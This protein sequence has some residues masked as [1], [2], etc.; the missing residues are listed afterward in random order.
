MQGKPNPQEVSDSS[1]MNRQEGSMLLTL[2]L[3]IIA[4]SILPAFDWN[5]SPPTF[6]PMPMFLGMILAIIVSV[7]STAAKMSR[8]RTCPA[9]G[10]RAPADALLGP[11]C[12]SIFPQRHG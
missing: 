5:H 6:N 12:G 11:Y 8:M 7:A 4:I 9:C 2:M 10:R 3:F 1:A